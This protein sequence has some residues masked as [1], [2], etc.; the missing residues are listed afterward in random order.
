MLESLKRFFEELWSIWTEDASPRQKLAIIFALIAGPALGALAVA[1]WYAK[2]GCAIHGTGTFLAYGLGGVILTVG[3][4]MVVCIAVMGFLYI[5]EGLR[6]AVV[7]IRDW[8]KARRRQREYNAE[9]GHKSDLDWDRVKWHVIFWPVFL[10]VIAG[11]SL[12]MGWIVW[13]FVC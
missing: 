2:N 3:A 5:P 7:S 13:N 8:N 10:T 1:G 4:A 11:L 12:T 9:H 6:A